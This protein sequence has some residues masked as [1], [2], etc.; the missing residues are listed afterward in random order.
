MIYPL[1]FVMNKS[2][3]ETMILPKTVHEVL[4]KLEKNG[5]EAYVVGGCVR[6]ALMGIEPKD[7]DVTTDA[8]P[9]EV[10]SV[11]CGNPVIETGIMHGTVTVLIDHFPIEV[12]TFR[13]DGEYVDLRRPLRVE[14]TRSINEDLARRDFTIN[15]I[16]YSEKSGIVDPF[17]GK[18]DLA[19]GII[20]CVGDPKKRF[21]EDALRILR[22]VRFASVLGFA[23]EPLTQKALL[24]KKDTIKSVAI[25]RISSE[26]FSLLCGKNIENVLIEYSELFAVIVPELSLAFEFLQNNPYHAYDVY[27]HTAKV[28]ANTSPKLDIRLA[29]F[30]HD[31][32]KPKTYS[33]DV[34]GIG[35]FYGH[36]KLSS[37]MADTIL[38][39]MKTDN[40]T[41]EKTILLVLYHDIQI[42][43]ERKAVKRVLNR[44]S[45]EFFLDLINLKKADVSGQHPDLI[46]RVLELDT[47]VRIYE[48]IIRENECFNL[49][50]LVISGGDLI[51]L[52]VV[53]G[54]QI[55]V[56]LNDCLSKVISGILSNNKD[57]LIEYVLSIY[58]ND[59]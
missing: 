22:A 41:R 10:K 33:Q 39:R 21:E 14:F 2:W 18:Q 6:D 36:Q 20:R 54:K 34:K 45:E 5:Y 35:H 19:D 29:A 50:D 53:P 55:G 48:D 12:T 40:E 28:V 24:E 31:I 17:E 26:F 38:R 15:A 49:K 58:I 57:M 23:I 59:N 30:F 4:A 27:T 52:G 11:F 47:L 56:I 42:K 1:H 16:A 44:F 8:T 43:P 7:F 32:G 13:I 3:G 51:L 46:G 25:E 37:Q 9:R